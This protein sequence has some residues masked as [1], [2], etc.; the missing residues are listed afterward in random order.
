LT[1]LVRSPQL[2]SSGSKTFDVTAIAK[3][4]NNV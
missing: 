1:L 4:S 3:D 2:S